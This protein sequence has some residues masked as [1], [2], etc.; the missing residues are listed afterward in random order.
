MCGGGF[1]IVAP[2]SHHSAAPL[3]THNFVSAHIEQAIGVTHLD[4][5]IDY[6]NFQHSGHT[7]A[8]F[9]YIHYMRRENGAE[10]VFGNV[11]VHL[12]FFTSLAFNSDL[13]K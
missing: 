2:T 7:K 5:A 6:R 8:A 12:Q 1:V 10:R 4:K 11:W 3:S 13:P 9:R